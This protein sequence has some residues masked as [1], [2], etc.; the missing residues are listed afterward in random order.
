MLI[1][2]QVVRKY[3]KLMTFLYSKKKIIVVFINL[4]IKELIT[5]WNYISTDLV[6]SFF[7]K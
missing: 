4:S 7:A 2:I 1:E 3:V 5:R 6:Q